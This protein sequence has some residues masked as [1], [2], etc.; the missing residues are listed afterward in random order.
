MTRHAELSRDLALALGYHPESVRIYMGSS[1]PENDWC[2]VY[3]ITNDIGP[4]WRAFDYRNARVALPLLRWLMESHRCEPG[5]IDTKQKW[6]LFAPWGQ[7]MSTET[8]ADTLEL[9]IARAVIAVGRG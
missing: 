2:E 8:Y 1:R 9:A 6:Y 7:F 3:R 4:Y 5:Y